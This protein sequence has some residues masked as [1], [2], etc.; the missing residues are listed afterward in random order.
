[1][2]KKRG[3]YSSQRQL[4]RRVRILR[5]TRTHFEK[6]GA[7]AVTMQA[8][9]EISEVSTKTLY[10]LFGSRDLL[11]LETASERLVELGLSD[12]VLAAEAG[13]P[14]LLAYTAG[15]MKQFVEMPKYARAVISILVGPDL[16]PEAAFER[17]GV[18]QRFAHT[19]LEI[20]ATQGELRDDLDLN[21]L[22]NH[23]ATNQ[24]G[25]V[26]WWEKGLIE[27]EQLETHVS[28]SHYTTLIPVSVGARRQQMEA[29]LDQLLATKFNKH[30]STEPH[31]FDINKKSG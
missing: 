31:V 27:L 7:S 3:P 4:D 23:L 19:S 29:E 13:L 22:A 11:L 8:I 2:G 12:F 6:Y 15:S 9:A 5:A 1:M 30:G 25:A 24:W 28:L 10:N 26:L 20:A 17:L 14:R 16:P 21:E 18:V